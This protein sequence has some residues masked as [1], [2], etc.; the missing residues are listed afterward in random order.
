MSL[1]SQTNTWL[2]FWPVLPSLSTSS[3]QTQFSC[4]CGWMAWVWCGAGRR[5]GKWTP[6]SWIF[7]LLFYYYLSGPL[8]VWT[9]VLVMLARL[10]L[11]YHWLWK[12]SW[13]SCVLPLPFLQL[14]EEKKKK[15]FEKK[16]MSNIRFGCHCITHNKLLRITILSF[17][18]AAGSIAR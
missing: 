2:R 10:E 11:R 7:T 8:F 5:D 13:L 3:T 9:F 18:K 15:I 12:H 17:S 4:R 6:R 14:K 16:Q 1:Y